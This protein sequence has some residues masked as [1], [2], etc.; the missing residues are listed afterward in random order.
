MFRLFIR[1]DDEI[2]EYYFHT[3]MFAVG[4]FIHVNR[5][6]KTLKSRGVI[7]TYRIGLVKEA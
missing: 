3:I 7:K 5:L 6:A 1:R 2:R 4:A